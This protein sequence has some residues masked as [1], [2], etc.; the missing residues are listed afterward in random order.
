MLPP[1]QPFAVL[2]PLAL[3]LII[4]CTETSKRSEGLANEC[5]SEVSVMHK[6]AIVEVAAANAQQ[7][8]HVP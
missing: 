8:P 2:A 4:F 3:Q 7:E 1:W 6:L 5:L